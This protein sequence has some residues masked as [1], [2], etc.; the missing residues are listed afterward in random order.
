MRIVSLETSDNLELNRKERQEES[1]KRS[2]DY[3]LPGTYLSQQQ[4]E[5]DFS[6]LYI[7]QQF[8][9]SIFPV[10]PLDDTNDI[11]ISNAKR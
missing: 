3:P 7:L 4:K 8:F 6:I 10:S 11:F 5:S 1:W 2:T 9:V